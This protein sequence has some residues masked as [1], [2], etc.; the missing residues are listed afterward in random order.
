MRWKFVGIGLAAGIAVSWLLVEGVA[1]KKESLGLIPLPQKVE[2][3]RGMFHLRPETRIVVDAAS[4]GTGEYLETRLRASTGY[5]LPVSGEVEGLEDNITLTTNQAPKRLGPEGYQLEVAPDAVVIRATGSAGLFYGVQTLLELFPPEAVSPKPVTSVSWKAPCVWIED[6]PRFAWRGLMLDV[7]RH[8]F[9]KHEIKQ[10]LEVMALHKLNVFHWHLTD[11]QGWRIEIKKYPRLTEVGGW[12]HRIGFNLD[13]KA[14]RAYAPDGRYGGFYTQQDVR[15]IVA[16]AL[17]RHITIVPEIEMPAHASAALA[18]YPEFSCF[19]EK[20]KYSTDPGTEALDGILCPGKEETFQFLTNV[21]SEV[22]ELFPGKYIHVGGD[23]VSTEN[24]KHCPQCQERMRTEGLKRE[25]DLEGYMMG[26]INGFLQ[27]K[28]RTMVGW[29]EIAEGQAPTNAVIM[30]WLG[31]AT[32]A[33]SAGHDVVMTPNAFCYFDYYQSR[34]REAEPPASGAY[35]PLGKVYAFEPIPTN[36][37]AGCKRR[38]LGGQ[39]NVWTEYMPSLRQVEYMTFP[40][41]CAMAEVLWSPRFSRDWPDFEQRLAVHLH[42]LDRM[43]IYY[44]TE[45]GLLGGN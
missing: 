12:R 21:L 15:E 30:D 13:P 4:R 25:S 33:T 14:S 24:W 35:L 44:R 38:I 1:G 10:V 41:L 42:R 22:V 23:E 37:A 16:Y 31:C 39:A 17:A 32:Q 7:S 20:G 6:R 8:F 45:P 9:N 3:R 43:G 2:R 28:G 40:R 26:R 27:S 18:A 11:D 34:D 19:P 36:L 29:S 5:L